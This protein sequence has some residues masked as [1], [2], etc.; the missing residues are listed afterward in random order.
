MEC[1]KDKTIIE[2]L[3][4]K[5]DELKIDPMNS[6]RSVYASIIAHDTKASKFELIALGTG[7]KCLPDVII[8][9]HADELIHDMHAEI[10]CKRSFISFIYEQ[11]L[12]LKRYNVSSNNYLLFDQELNKHYWNP[13]LDLLFYT[14]QSPCK[15][16]WYVIFQLIFRR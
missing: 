10:V 6:S 16:N 11:L 1:S 15:K 2:T 13:D 14:S 4:S 12:N 3:R 9:E 7:I 5:L 8:S